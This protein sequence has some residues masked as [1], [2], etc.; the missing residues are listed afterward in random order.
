MAVTGS[1]LLILKKKTNKNDINLIFVKE[2]T[3]SLF[4]SKQRQK[5]T[6]FHSLGSTATRQCNT[7][8]CGESMALWPELGG[9][10]MPLCF[11]DD[12][13]PGVALFSHGSTETPGWTAGV[14][15]MQS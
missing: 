11:G 7:K 4:H 12:H 5:S 15:L 13:I 9:V 2:F 3:K 6:P 8:M 1:T 10:E 14:Q